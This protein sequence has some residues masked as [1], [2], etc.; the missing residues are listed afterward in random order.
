[1]RRQRFH[2]PAAS[3]SLFP[4]LAVLICTMGS[5]IVLLVLMVQLARV[6][7]KSVAEQRTEEEEAEYAAKA[8]KRRQELEDYQWRRDV[9]EQQRTELAAKLADKRLELSHLEDHIRRLEQRWKQLEAELAELQRLREAGQQGQAQIR[10]ELDRLQ[11]LIDQQ[12]KRL[13]EAREEAARR[14]RSFTIIPYQGPRGTRR[15]PI[16]VEC[17]ESGIIIQP[18]GIVLRPKDFAGPLGPGNPLDAALRAIRE[19]WARVEGDD[20]GEPY[21][22]LVVRPDGAVAYSMAR[23]AMASWEDEFGYELVDADMVLEYP[24]S[25]PTLKRLLEA[26]VE[27]SRQRQALLAAAMPSRFDTRALDRFALPERPAKSP[28]G[29]SSGGPRGS[30]HG[31]ASGTERPAPFRPAGAS[32]QDRLGDRAAEKASPAASGEP[33]QRS[34]PGAPDR[35]ELDD[36]APGTGGGAAMKSMALSRGAN[37]ALPNATPR[38][39]GITRPIAVEC[40]PDR[41][42]ILPDRGGVGQPRVVPLTGSVHASI[43]EFVSAIWTHMEQWGMAVAGGYWK[44]VLKVTVGLGAEQ[45]FRELKILLEDSGIEVQRR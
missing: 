23:A 2:K 7:A 17:T 33:S 5:L 24:P 21:P 18:E 35:S 20:A 4:F 15:R 9:L 11:A 8:A 26:T 45:R 32:P 3:V 42:V 16:Y 30:R 6:H 27:T 22:L 38:A 14:Q 37:W 1:M 41:L 12:R 13:A 19:Y 31:R 36:G 40:F 44:P 25:D 28:A 43:E 29:G 39:T 34:K 10:S